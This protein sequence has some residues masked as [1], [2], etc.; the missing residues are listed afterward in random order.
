MKLKNIAFIS[1]ILIFLVGWSSPAKK[2]TNN[3]INLNK[4]LI[5]QTHNLNPKVLNASLKAYYKAE[6]QGINKKHILTIVDYSLP[7]TEKRLWVIDMNKSKILFNTWVAHG[8]N[9]GKAKP[10][11]FSNKSKSLK[12]SLGVFIT[13]APYT[14]GKG[15]S[16]RIKGLEHNIN[17]NAYNRT[18]VFHGAWYVNPS[19][20]KTR[21]M[22]GRSWGCFAVDKKIIKPLI[23]TIKN[24]SLLVAYY[25]DKNW[26]QHSNFI[27]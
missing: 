16:M 19:F 6:K 2:E 3:T 4:K 18:I 25:P 17:D 14:G 22:M 5:S 8:T 26:L 27:N 24:K 12:S 7:S 20:A 23:N 1:T 21:G 11:S 10:Y 9:S 15:Y 13:D